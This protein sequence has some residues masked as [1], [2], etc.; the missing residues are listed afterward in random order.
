VRQGELPQKVVVFG[1]GG[2]GR[3]LQSVLTELEKLDGSVELLGFLDSSNQGG[4]GKLV[5]GSDELIAS[6]DARYLVAVADPRCRE[7][8]DRYATEA[9]RS[10]FTLLHRLSCLER[11]V[12]IGAGSV[13]LS[14]AC[15]E[16]EARVGRQ[17]LVNVNAVIG[18]ESEVGSYTTVSPSAVIGGGSCLGE[19]VFIG[20]GVV[21][22]PGRTVG[23]DA[24]IGAGSVVVRDV[25]AGAR[26]VGAPA[27][28]V[29]G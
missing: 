2:L 4:G 23:D 22:L 25:P 14:G 16:V 24:V 17:V 15:I 26:V 27:R 12:T 20:A 11:P 10:A 19:R 8:I 6:V 3:R 9:G 18:H 1:Y 13:V 5:L 7:R 28:P 21:V 29:S